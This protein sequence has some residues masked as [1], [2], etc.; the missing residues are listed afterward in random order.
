MEPTPFH[1]TEQFDLSFPFRA[2]DSY[3]APFWFPLHWHEP[4]ELLYILKGKLN[5][6]LNGKSLECR[7]GD[8]III[9]TDL[10]HGFFD[11][12]PETLAR[13]FQFGRSL[14]NETLKE[15]QDSQP[16]NEQAA[17]D[18]EPVFR[19]KT[20]ISYS[21]DPGLHSC[22]ENVLMEIFNENEQKLPGH[23]LAIKSGLCNFTLGLLRKINRD[24]KTVWGTSAGI[25]AEKNSTQYLER[26]F[27][28]ILNHYSRPE[29]NLDDAAA[30]AGLS[31]Y[32]LS[33][34]LKEKTGQGFHEHL[35]LVRLRNAE[36]YLKSSDMPIIDIAYL[37]GF[38]SLATF[39]RIFKTHT[40]LT[41][42]VFRRTQAS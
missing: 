18:E 16:L 21:R 10:V 35:S 17:D 22:L 29:I 13:I 28:F 2:W 33:R 12:Q 40:G 11:P 24:E 34:F 32:Y 6:S 5:L 31:K 8:I 41:P 23:K 27:S 1:E 38:Q 39:N 30:E 7:Q 20:V 36:K 4:L 19:R 37:S 3:K 15:L 9:D 14:V 26:I 25:S 42:S